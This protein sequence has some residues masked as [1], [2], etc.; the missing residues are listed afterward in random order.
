MLKNYHETSYTIRTL[1]VNVFV[2]IVYHSTVLSFIKA[3]L[4]PGSPLPLNRHRLADIM[5]AL[6]AHITRQ[7]YRLSPQKETRRGFTPVLPGLQVEPYHPA[8]VAALGPNKAFILHKLWEW[9]EHNRRD[10]INLRDGHHWTYDTYDNW[11]KNHFWWLSADHLR[12]LICEM[13]KGG[14][15]ISGQFTK[16]SAVKWYRVDI[17]AVSKLIRMGGEN[18]RTPGDKTRLTGQKTRN[19]NKDEST[20]KN[21]QIKKTASRKQQQQPLTPY[22]SEIPTELDD[23]AVADPSGQQPESISGE[24]SIDGEALSAHIK[25]QHRDGTNDTPSSPS[26]AAPLLPKIGE[27]A[28]ALIDDMLHVYGSE[29]VAGHAVNLIRQYGEER[30]RGVHWYTASRMSHWVNPVG[31][32]TSELRDNKYSL[33]P[34]SANDGNPYLPDEPE[35]ETTS[36]SSRL[37]ADDTQFI[38][39]DLQRLDELSLRENIPP[40]PEPVGLDEKPDGSMTAR[41]VWNTAK[42]QCS[43]LFD[44]FSYSIWLKEA[45]LLGYDAEAATFR[46]AVPS[47]H[48]QENLQHRHYRKIQRIFEG[49][50]NTPA[51]IVF[52]VAP[53]PD[54]PHR[55]LTP[56]EREELVQ[57]RAEYCAEHQPA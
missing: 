22:E 39:M 28:A 27:T 12:K 1:L 45:Q 48:A 26:S 8:L 9:Q 5:L 30:V 36:L 29:L 43:L 13:E 49:L 34:R 16:G 20:N 54:L 15:M 18:L 32:L 23:V 6:S 57:L 55:P 19:K 7:A 2:W 35:A 41:E 17:Q 14:L 3:R 46:I 51:N 33:E 37:A 50:S 21:P 52:E 40:L 25:A 24:H 42:H 56:Q 4:L 44:Q 11:Q 47:A 53:Q 38:E 31:F 10:K